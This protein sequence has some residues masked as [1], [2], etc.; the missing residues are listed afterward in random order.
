[1]QATSTHQAFPFHALKGGDRVN[2]RI[3]WD[4]RPVLGGWWAAIDS[5][6]AVILRVRSPH[7]EV[8]VQL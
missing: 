1:M 8:L 7:A 4:T 6:G 5:A 3:V 2:G